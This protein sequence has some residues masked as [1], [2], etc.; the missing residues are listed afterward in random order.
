M[1]WLVARQSRATAETVGLLDRGILAPG[2]KAD[3]NVIDYD[4]L[5]MRRPEMIYDLPAGGKRLIQPATGYRHTIVSGTE[6]YTDGQPTGA[7]PGRLV[8]GHQPD[9]AQRV[10]M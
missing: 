8:R 10:H 2:Y 7:L 4:E 9:P 6:V 1:P 5:T 3:L